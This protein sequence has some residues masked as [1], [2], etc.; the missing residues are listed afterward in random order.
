VKTG[1]LFLIEITTKD[2]F[3][4]FEG[5]CFEVRDY[6]AIGSGSRLGIVFVPPKVVYESASERLEFKLQTMTQTADAAK[7]T[8]D[9]QGTLV[10][11]FRHAT[12]DDLNFMAELGRQEQA[13]AFWKPKDFG[14]VGNL[15]SRNSKV[16][17]SF[18]TI[19]LRQCHSF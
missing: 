19:S 11:R 15:F 13:D 3:R 8:E 9:S 6:D 18:L 17:A 12:L 10:L 4:C 7:K 16:G 14:K 2:L 1:S 5:I